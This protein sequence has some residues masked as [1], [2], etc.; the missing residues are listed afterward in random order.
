MCIDYPMFFVLILYLCISPNTDLSMSTITDV[1]FRLATT[2]KIMWVLIW[3]W[4]SFLLL[5][6]GY[7]FT[8]MHVYLILSRTLF[9]ISGSCTI[10]I[11]SWKYS[12]TILLPFRCCSVWSYLH[13]LLLST[14]VVFLF[15]I[16]LSSTALPIVCCFGLW[17]HLP[18]IGLN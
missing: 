11:R 2:L 14:F 16:F 13:M 4:S 6:L 18:T 12:F 10:L 7:Y 15:F 3:S 1:I 5:F 9:L 17:F 8:Y